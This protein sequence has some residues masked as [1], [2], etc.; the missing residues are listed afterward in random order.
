MPKATRFLVAVLCGCA[1]GSWTGCGSTSAPVEHSRQARDDSP[2]GASP[3]QTAANGSP[4]GAGVARGLRDQGPRL[5]LSAPRALAVN[6]AT[7]AGEAIHSVAWDNYP[8]V[9]GIGSDDGPHVRLAQAQPMPLPIDGPVLEPPQEPSTPQSA[10]APNSSAIVPLPP[11]APAPPAEPVASPLVRFARPAVAWQNPTPPFRG[12]EFSAVERQANAQTALGFQLGQRGA[13]YSA[14]AQFV[15][16][17]RT[18]AEALDSASGGNG[19]EQML[20][21]GLQA[22]DEADDFAPRSAGI[23]SDLDVAQIVAGHQTPVL[24]DVPLDG[25]N[26]STAMSRYLTFAQDQLAGCAAGMPSGST[27]LY[28]LGRIYRVPESLHGPVDRTH[29]AKAVALYQA[30]LSVDNRNYLAA[31]ELGVLLAQF[32]RLPEAKTALLHS[33]A[34]YPLPATWQNLAAV[35]RALGERD[36]A[37]RAHQEALLAVA[38][39]YRGGA[40]QTIAVEWLDPARFAATTPLNVDGP[41]NNHAGRQT[42]AA[43]GASTSATR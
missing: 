32:G 33:I 18:M 4:D 39:Q 1:I 37:D 17:L 11:M 22:L 13:I 27:A 25:V 36:L 5:L 23:Q 26:C 38:R 41:A 29:G 2:N 7:P 10:G 12:D 42:V 15:A 3:I 20:V 9:G 6:G 14:R 24:K 35:H 8:T 28:A 30:A 40:G 31:N 19:H 34:V 21:A 43:G 16:A